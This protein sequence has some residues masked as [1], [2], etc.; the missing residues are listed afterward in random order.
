MDL[1]R[2][3]F[4]SMILYDYK[5]GLIAHEWFTSL[6]KAFVGSA[7]LRA[8]VGIWFRGFRMGRQSLEDEAWAGCPHTSAKD[9]KRCDSV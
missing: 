8:T 3:D 7:L 2:P 6:T 1:T 4:H 9:E 5:R